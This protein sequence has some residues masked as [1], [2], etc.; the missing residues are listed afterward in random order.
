MREKELDQPSSKIEHRLVLRADRSIPL[1][2][3][4]HPAS[5]ANPGPK[6]SLLSLM[7]LLQ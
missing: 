6:G 7:N 4:L 3:P 1:S 5:R 2:I